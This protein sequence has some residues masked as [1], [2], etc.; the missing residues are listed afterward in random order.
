VDSARR[1]TTTSRRARPRW[2]RSPTVAAGVV[3]LKPTTEVGATSILPS[4]NGKTAR[5]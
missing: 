2:R 1:P 3:Q 4:L 5:S